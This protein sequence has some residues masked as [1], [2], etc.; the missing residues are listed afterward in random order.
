MDTNA[1]SDI[2][3][4]YLCLQKRDLGLEAYHTGRDQR[5]D[6]SSKQLHSGSDAMDRRQGY[7]SSSGRASSGSIK[8]QRQQQTGTV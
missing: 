1:G 4:R 7:L 3:S 8:T 5:H 2:L 6:E